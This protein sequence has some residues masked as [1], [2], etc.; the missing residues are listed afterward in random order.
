MVDHVA[1]GVEPLLD[2]VVDFVVHRTDVVGDLACGTEVGSAF[3]ADG[4]RVEAGPPRTVASFGLDAAVG[5]AF[6]YGRD[7]RRIESARQQHAVG[8][9]GHQLPSDGRFERRA[10]RGRV[11]VALLDG[12]VVE[13]VARVPARRLPLAA[14]P[15][16]PRLEGADDVAHP[17]ERLQL[18]CD[19]APFVGIPADVERNDADGVAGDEILVALDVVEREGEDAV[20][21]VEQ[22]RAVFAVER[23]DHLAVRTG[24]EVVLAGQLAPQFAVVVDLAVDGQHQPAVGAVKGLPARLRVDD[25]EA[26]VR[27][28]GAR[29]AVDARPIGP[30]MPDF[31][32]HPQHLRTQVLTV[33]SD[34]E[35]SDKAAHNSRF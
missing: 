31:S 34:F 26:F 10:Q 32:R 16:V 1:Q 30:S 21:P 14:P 7:D 18:R 19:V 23:E 27:E 3:Q 22:P 13:P 33:S 9:V 8:N 29:A 24:A 5:E 15:I 28:H 4:E 12:F 17:F 20:E 11:G 25:R 6:G 35:H 2:G